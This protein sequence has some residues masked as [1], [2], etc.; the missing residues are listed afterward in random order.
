LLLLLS[1]SIGRTRLKTCLQEPD[2]HRCDRCW[3]ACTSPKRRLPQL[4][5]R[6]TR[7]RPDRLRYRAYG[8]S[9]IKAVVRSRALDKCARSGGDWN[10]LSCRS[11]NTTRGS[12]FQVMLPQYGE[13]AIMTETRRQPF[14]VVCCSSWNR[15]CDMKAYELQLPKPSGVNVFIE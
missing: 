1:G 2:F 14:D 11:A 7:L 10:Y 13:T 9:Q 3:L 8:D 5:V 4:A 12:I 6:R 15:T